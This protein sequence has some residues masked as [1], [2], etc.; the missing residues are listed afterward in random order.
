[1]PP[2]QLTCMNLTILRE[3]LGLY[4]HEPTSNAIIDEQKLSAVCEKIKDKPSKSASPQLAPLCWNL[5]I[6]INRHPPQTFS[7]PQ[8]FSQTA[9]V[10]LRCAKI[11]EAAEKELDM[12]LDKMLANVLVKLTEGIKV[13][14]EHYASV[15][16]ELMELFFER[17]HKHFNH[18]LEIK[19][20]RMSLAEMPCIN[21]P[22]A[23]INLH[24]I[25]PGNTQDPVLKQLATVAL[26]SLCR[27][28]L[29]FQKGPLESVL[30]SLQPFHA[31]TGRNVSHFVSSI[32]KLEFWEASEWIFW[33]W[34]SDHKS[35]YSEQLTYFKRR[36]HLGVSLPTDPSR[37][38]IKLVSAL[39]AS[40]QLVDTML[41][42][43]L[44]STDVDDEIIGSCLG[45]VIK[46]ECHVHVE[47]I[48]KII[49]RVHGK[50]L[51]DSGL[52]LLLPALDSLRNG[53]FH[54]TRSD[55][56][57][58]LFSILNECLL[59]LKL[60]V[61]F[62]V[63]WTSS[64]LKSAIDNKKHLNIANLQKLVRGSVAGLMRSYQIVPEDMKIKVHKI[65]GQTLS[66]GADIQ[67]LQTFL[68]DLKGS[69]GLVLEHSVFN[70][71]SD[72]FNELSRLI[73]KEGA[74]DENMLMLWVKVLS[75]QINS[76]PKAFNANSLDTLHVMS[77]LISTNIF[78]QLKQSQYL[79]YI[80]D[81]VRE[82][83]YKEDLITLCKQLT[84]FKCNKRKFGPKC[85]YS[86][87]QIQTAVDIVSSFLETGQFVAENFCSFQ[88]LAI[89]NC[90]E[91]DLYSYLINLAL[92]HAS[93][94]DFKKLVS[95]FSHWEI[96]GIQLFCAEDSYVK[97]GPEVSKLH[98]LYL[99]GCPL[100][101]LKLGYEKL[102]SSLKSGIENTL[103]TVELIS[104]LHRLSVSTNNLSES[105]YFLKQLFNLAETVKSENVK[106]LAEDL[107][108]ELGVLAGNSLRFMSYAGCEDILRSS[109]YRAF[110][111]EHNVI[112]GH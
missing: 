17:L 21:D 50:E 31:E 104:Y 33:Y 27:L 86:D 5:L 10:T 3:L 85:F 109:A 75:V 91:R 41:D 93:V 80:Y 34:L 111:F 15:V 4:R 51:S 44:N 57:I 101:A 26:E 14:L 84:H 112:T 98:A 7:N 16:E 59:D 37:L 83:G 55:K 18:N 71:P 99:K 28:I 96:A 103:Q 30:S 1:M 47:S 65:I 53:L 46:E 79:E 48:S 9:K 11:V 95:H 110:T 22:F 100:D 108:N 74:S 24:S 66:T 32:C 70:L 39:L 62:Y 40:N 56:F 81:R 67:S 61:K 43:A 90:V 88:N 19:I 64:A 42:V 82:L 69:L 73:F 72:Y 89:R 38:N 6:Q 29:I 35:I 2:L 68:D 12:D 102:K 87:P 77:K 49:D 54:L 58:D 107:Q 25:A 97:Y 36:C 105:K 94:D 78:D 106:K 13:A 60:P 8:I 63:S 23:N 52:K 45:L 20:R 76:T 92:V